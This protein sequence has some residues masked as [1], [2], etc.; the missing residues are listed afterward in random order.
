M[1]GR[2]LSH[3]DKRDMQ[4]SVRPGCCMHQ[5]RGRKQQQQ[6]RS[7]LPICREWPALRFTHVGGQFALQLLLPSKRMSSLSPGKRCV[8]EQQAKRCAASGP[9]PISPCIGP[10]RPAPITEWGGGG[11][12]RSAPAAPVTSVLQAGH[13]WAACLALA[14][15]SLY[16]GIGADPFLFQGKTAPRS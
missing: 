13:Q 12:F 8:L 4:D 2:G 9:H 10:H 14:W 7:A 5:Q 11:R 3:R 1:G 6:R 16:A 15:R